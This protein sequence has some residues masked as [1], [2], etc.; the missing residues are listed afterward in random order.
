MTTIAEQNALPI[1][2]PME[3]YIGI[4]DH[5]NVTLNYSYT[6]SQLKVYDGV[7]DSGVWPMRKLADL[8]GAGFPLN[9]QHH[10]YDPA[11]QASASNGKLGLRGNIG[12]NIVVTVTGSGSI[13]VLSIRVHDCA[14]VRV[15]GAVHPVS[16]SLCIFERG[17][18]SATLTF[19]PSDPTE[20]IEI[21]FIRPGICLDVDGEN[22]I[23]ATLA[24]R[25][26]LT[27]LSPTLPESEIDIKIFMGYDVSDLLARVK[28][29]TPITYQA[30][31]DSDLSPVRKFY[32]SDMVTWEKNVITVQGVDAVH[33]LDSEMRNA[34][35]DGVYYGESWESHSL[36]LASVYKN[37]IID[38][39]DGDN[40]LE[41]DFAIYSRDIIDVED[42][43]T[44]DGARLHFSC[45]SGYSGYVYFYDEEETYLGYN[46][47]YSSGTTILQSEYPTATSI[48]ITIRTDYGEPMSPSQWTVASASYDI[49]T[50]DEHSDN[51]YSVYRWM[52]Y[53]L[54]QKMGVGKFT[55]E[56]C[57]QLEEYITEESDT[58]L[59][60]NARMLLFKK[61]EARKY[62]A[63]LMNLFH[64]TFPAGYLTTG[65]YFWPVY[66]DAGIPALT[67]SRPAP[68][69]DIYE[70]ECGDVASKIER[71][72][73]KLTV[74]H[75]KVGISQAE[76]GTATWLLAEGVLQNIPDLMHD[77]E[78]RWAAS[79]MSFDQEVLTD[80]ETGYVTYVGPISEN[81][82]TERFPLTDSIYESGY[83]DS[84][85]TPGDI[86]LNG[87]LSHWFNSNFHK[88]GGLLYSN[89]IP[90]GAMPFVY[91]VNEGQGI[92]LHYNTQT[93]PWNLDQATQWEDA[94]DAGTIEQ[95]AMQSTLHY[96]GSHIE[97]ISESLNYT[98][99]SGVGND[100]E[101]EANIGG[102]MLT[103]GASGSK[104]TREIYPAMAYQSLADRS[105]KTG[106]FKWKGNPKMQPRD[107]VRFHKRDGTVLTVTIE[108]ITL[109]HEKG[110][111]IAEITYRQGVV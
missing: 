109:T 66:V 41:S 76:T 92:L 84:A 25:S 90:N 107:I 67:W 11:V 102:R 91:E 110:G 83:T 33:R 55:A 39:R 97:E 74:T 53:M 94:M 85:F 80:P 27:Y 40:I 46:E 86:I 28:D 63:A 96:V 4:D 62:M 1:R 56:T 19:L 17:A 52:Q 108:Q 100:E 73:K 5:E 75:S 111:T 51:L 58:I 68:K 13:G 21:D 99:H 60:L 106:S 10:L 34:Y 87:D 29:E 37:G 20:R 57:Q 95:G 71:Y 8:D 12:Q 16:A 3:V 7:I 50:R 18:S 22:L 64:L 105:S 70:S 61:G 15:N 31:Y 23:S 2:K 26:D 30:G 32:V 98:L 65:Q 88:I 35:V 81:G 47:F 38:P 48:Q 59:S 14:G 49:Q 45:S 103:M 9:S 79:Q 54:E 89:D 78:V 101:V 104:G 36:S 42:V 69:W 77:F 72:T 44:E 24:L 82:Y 93:M 43:M 6:A